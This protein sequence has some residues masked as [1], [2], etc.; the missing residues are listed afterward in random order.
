MGAWGTG[1]RQDD[2]VLDVVGTFE[3]HLKAGRSVAEATAAVKAQC[4]GSLSDADEGPLIWI[5]IAEVQWTYGQLDPQ[6]LKH[7]QDD[8]ASER[9]LDLWREDA[10]VLSRRI[11]V[12][13]KFIA[14]IS[15]PNPRP[16]KGAK[17]VVRAPKFQAGDC[18]SIRLAN[19]QYGAALVLAADH[20]EVENGRNLVVVLDYL[21]TEKPGLDVFRARNWLI[22]THHHWQN[23]VELAWYLP[24]GFRKAKDRIEVV[25][26]IQILASDPNDSNF[27]N[28][29][30]KVGEE[31]VLQRQWDANRG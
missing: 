19:G 16:K 14:R 4:A 27:Y 7:V 10:R 8:F 20:S 29:W 12:L 17:T 24:V 15:A 23:H 21:A 25:G 9:G 6:V 11:A 2:V 22:C 26:Q 1:I 5:A 3:D 18:L 13:E 31:V 28:G 30:G